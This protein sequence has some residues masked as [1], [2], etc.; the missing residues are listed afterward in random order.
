MDSIIFLLNLL[1]SALY[2]ML[3]LRIILP[4]IPHK[5]ESQW[6]GWLYT[7]T[8]PTLALFRQAMPP[9]KFGYDV[10]PFI[11]LFFLVLL[12]RIIIFTVGGF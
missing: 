6:W 7:L 2:L 9:E 8:D 5:K 1:F 11:A 3:G 12:Q 10:S 4:F